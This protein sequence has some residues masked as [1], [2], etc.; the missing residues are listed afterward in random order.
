MVGGL[1]AG[2]DSWVRELEALLTG[3]AVAESAT[4]ARSRVTNILE[5]IVA[6][7]PM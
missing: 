3:N 5:I 4:K 1:T 6:G 7:D 2:D